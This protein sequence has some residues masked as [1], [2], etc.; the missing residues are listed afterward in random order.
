MKKG[1]TSVDTGHEFGYPLERL[2]LHVS[3]FL[4]ETI[5]LQIGAWDA[6]DVSGHDFIGR[7]EGTAFLPNLSAADSLIALSRANKLFTNSFT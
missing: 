7:V 6:D 1:K 2:N 5:H 4:K 3:L